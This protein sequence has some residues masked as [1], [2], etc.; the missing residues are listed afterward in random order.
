MSSIANP[1]SR[2]LL[3]NIRRPKCFPDRPSRQCDQIAAEAAVVGQSLRKREHRRWSCWPLRPSGR[4]KKS[5][6]PLRV[7][8]SFGFVRGYRRLNRRRRLQPST[9]RRI[10]A[11]RSGVADPIPHRGAI[12]ERRI[13]SRATIDANRRAKPQ[14]GNR[15]SVVSESVS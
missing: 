7:R 13:L 12:I 15:I 1:L 2:A 4:W 5:I 6:V 9:L 10:N 11:R 8:S 14:G 3:M